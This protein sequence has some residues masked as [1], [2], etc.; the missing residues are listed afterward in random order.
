MKEIIKHD[1]REIN[2][3]ARY[4]AYASPLKK[5]IFSHNIKIVKRTI[6][7]LMFNRK[8]PVLEKKKIN[9]SPVKINAD[10]CSSCRVT[11][12]NYYKMIK[13]KK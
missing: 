1:D 12:T 10:P 5:Y 2:G 8:K 3:Q 6:Y 11:R 4:E 7:N 9:F 13:K